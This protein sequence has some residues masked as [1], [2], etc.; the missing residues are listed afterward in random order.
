MWLIT[1]VAGAGTWKDNSSSETEAYIR[2]VL[3]ETK[4]YIKKIKA[5]YILNLLQG[6]CRF[7]QAKFKTF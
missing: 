5:R 1:L 6:I 2:I 7:E 3:V 4:Q